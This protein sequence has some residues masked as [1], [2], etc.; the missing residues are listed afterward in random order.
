M[1]NG[2]L[3]PKNGGVLVAAAAAAAVGVQNEFI[4]VRRWLYWICCAM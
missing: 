2:P 3:G 1:L 4:F